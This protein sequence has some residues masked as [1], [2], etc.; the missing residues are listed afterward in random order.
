M[1]ERLGILI[2]NSFGCTHNDIITL[3]HM[4]AT[5]CTVM[6]TGVGVLCSKT[7]ITTNAAGF[8]NKMKVS[9]LQNVLL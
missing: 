2:S 3:H 8:G 9:S 4:T 6:L 1:R 5:T 7:A